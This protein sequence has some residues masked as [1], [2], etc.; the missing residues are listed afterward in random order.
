M[1]RP[2][3]ATKSRPARSGV[4]AGQ[5][6]A[7]QAAAA[8]VIASLGRGPVLIAAAAVVAIVLLVPAWVRLR[9]RW[10]YQWIGVGLRYLGRRHTLPPNAAPTALLELIA[11]NTRLATAEVAGEDAAVL[12]GEYGVTAL[13]ELG[14]GGALF[15]DL[16]R[17]LPNPAALLPPATVEAPQVRLQLLVDAAP[18]PAVRAGAGTPGTSYRQLTEGRML[19]RRQAILAVRVLRGEQWTEE[20]LRR[21]LSSA[22]RKARRRL[23]GLSAR[24]LGEAATLRV[25]AEL[26]HHDEAQAAR[27]AWQAIHLGGLLQASFRLRSWPDLRAETAANLIPRLLALPAAGTTVS[28]SVGPRPIEGDTYPVDLTVRLAATDM[29]GLTAAAQTLDRLVSGERATVRRLDGEQL[30]GLAATL[31]LGGDEAPTPPGVNRKLPPV[32]AGLTDLAIPEP[33]AGLML[34]RNRRGEPVTLRMFRPEATRALFVGGVRGAQLVVLRAIALGARVVVQTGRPQAWERFVRGASAPGEAILLVPPGRPI[35]AAPGTSLQPLLVVVDIGP[36][37]VDPNAAPGWQATLIVRDELSPVDLDALTRSDV[38]ILQ[39]LR[40]DEASLVGAA[41]GIGDS[42]QYLPR[43]RQ[44]M[45][46]VI[47]RRTLR[48]A[49]LTPTPIELQLVGPPARG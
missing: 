20:D 13:L 14:D 44:D 4:R 22:V 46:G 38:V 35:A 11:P 40:P 2:V 32:P 19:S 30:A 42:A 1:I 39:P 23:A 34:G 45:V 12:T 33:A 41:L 17:A 49:L 43:I 8:A 10:L 24:T 25:L 29:A 48:W 31:P 16:G 28:L 47:H 15:G 27:E 37:G 9:R 7:L 36:V 26:A 18:A 6:V 5:I 21:S 3:P